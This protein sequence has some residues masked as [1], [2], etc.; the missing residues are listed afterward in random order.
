MFFIEAFGSFAHQQA[1]LS[2]WALAVL[3]AYC[4]S[5]ILHFE[6]HGAGL[7][8]LFAQIRVSLSGEW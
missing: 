7:G 6:S 4:V 5:S 3:N 1:F 2:A 8:Y